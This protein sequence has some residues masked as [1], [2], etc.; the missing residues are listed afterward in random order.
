MSDE[1]KAA[2]D[3]TPE[4]LVDSMIKSAPVVMFSKVCG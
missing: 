2:S 3:Q 4:E 1:S